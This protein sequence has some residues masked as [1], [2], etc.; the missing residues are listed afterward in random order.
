MGL[1]FENL[2]LNNLPEV[3]NAMGLAGKLVIS[4]APFRCVR[5]ARGGVQV[6]LLVQTEGAAWIVE[7]KR[8]AELGLDVARELA[9]KAAR[10]PVREG[11]S[12]RTALVYD[13]RLSQSLVASDDIDRLISAKELLGLA[14]R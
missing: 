8:K 1:Q 5:A 13:G 14:E 2:I 4:A 6:D 3:I 9:Q 7:I 12:V 10:L 11:G